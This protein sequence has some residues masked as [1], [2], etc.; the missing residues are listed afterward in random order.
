MDPRSFLESLDEPLR[1]MV[2]ARLR[3]RRYDV[4]RLLGDEHAFFRALEEALGKHNVELLLAQAMAKPVLEA[5]RRA[6]DGGVEGFL[7]FAEGVGED[8][9]EAL[10]ASHLLSAYRGL[11][12]P[13]RLVKAEA[14][15]K[16]LVGKLQDKAVELGEVEA[17]IWQLMTQEC[18]V[19]KHIGAKK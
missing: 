2:L 16:A 17:Q 3:A 15:V 6:L 12:C 14:L 4:K 1:L 13:D 10:G 19:L 5:A 18:T 7:R 9:I 11:G 8:A